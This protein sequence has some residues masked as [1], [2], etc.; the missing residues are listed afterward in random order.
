MRRFS[1]IGEWIDLADSSRTF[2]HKI[3]QL[4][5]HDCLLKCLAIA[6]AAKQLYLV[7]E[8]EDGKVI[9]EQSYDTAIS[10]LIQRIESEKPLS[11][12]TFVALIISASYEML[13]AN[14]AE[15][16]N[17]LGGG[18][19]F[20]KAQGV[21]GSCGGINEVCFWVTARQE[22]VRCILSKSRL[23]YDPDL[24]NARLERMAQDGQEDL[25]FNQ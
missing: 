3:P 14:G 5:V 20:A 19:S 7:G 15:W 10:F 16:Q 22:V 25:A 21:N 6:T 8:F 11:T 1:E 13:N 23:R 2:S 24:W 12:K 9:A 18:L 17:H 4:A